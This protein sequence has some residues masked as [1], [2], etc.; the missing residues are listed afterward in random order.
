MKSND[1]EI[2]KVLADEKFW[3]NFI[4]RFNWTLI[5]FTYRVTA[6]IDTPDGILHITGGQARAIMRELT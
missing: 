4:S 5:G 3:K 2:K 1:L 6:T